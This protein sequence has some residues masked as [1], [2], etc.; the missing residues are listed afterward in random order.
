MYAINGIKNLSCTFLIVFHSY[1]YL[2]FA[3]YLIEHL[4]WRN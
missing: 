3:N 2:R 1:L 4:Q